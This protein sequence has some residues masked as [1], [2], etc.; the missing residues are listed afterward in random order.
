MTALPGQFAISTR[1]GDRLTAVD[2]GGR[3]HRRHSHRHLSSD[4]NR[5]FDRSTLW[6]DAIDRV[7]ALGPR[8][9]VAGHQNKQLDD[10]A[11]RTIAEIRQYLDDAEE[12]LQTENTAI[13]CFNAKLERYPNH[14]GRTVLWAGAT[15]L[16][17]LGGHPTSTSAISSSLPGCEPPSA[18][19]PTRSS[20]HA[21]NRPQ[22]KTWNLGCQPTS[23]GRVPFIALPAAT[24]YDACYATVRD[25]PWGVRERGRACIASR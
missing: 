12:L 25:V 18:P 4:D 19:L 5:P 11:E 3:I 8:H 7:A 22:E 16:Y 9:I 10:D 20:F 15:A 6:R 13:D 23:S 24:T 2:G 17:G 21:V 1:L 14:L